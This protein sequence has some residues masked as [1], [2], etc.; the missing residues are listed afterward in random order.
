LKK[1]SDFKKED[2]EKLD[3]LKIRVSENLYLSDKFKLGDNI[4]CNGGV[5]KDFRL[6]YIL[7]RV[8]G[9]KKK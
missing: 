2:I 8:T 3:E 6:G 7:K 5:N 9:L 4:T 1:K